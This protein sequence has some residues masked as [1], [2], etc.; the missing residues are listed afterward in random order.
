M[1][2]SY[3]GKVLHPNM[4]LYEIVWNLIIFFKIVLRWLHSL[5]YYPLS[6]Y[7]LSINIIYS[8]PSSCH[9]SPQLMIKML[10]STV[11]ACPCSI[12]LNFLNSSIDF[13]TFLHFHPPSAHLPLPLL[14]LLASQPVGQP[15]YIVYCYI[16]RPTTPH[17]I[18]YAQLYLMPYL[19]IFI[20]PATF[21]HSFL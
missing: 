16:L 1:I 19:L 2:C 11:S 7:L 10:L 20:P 8:H 13:L 5:W 4:K 17:L 14:F 6:I 3:K 9:Q 12:S 18:L 15:L 21:P